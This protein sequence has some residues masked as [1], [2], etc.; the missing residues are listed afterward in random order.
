MRKTTGTKWVARVPQSSGPRGTLAVPRLQELLVDPS[1]AWVL[2]P[3][4]A[5]IPTRNALPALSAVSFRFL[6]TEASNHCAEQP[7][8][9]SL[10]LSPGA[11]IPSTGT[12]LLTKQRFISGALSCGCLFRR[13]PQKG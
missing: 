6:E 5:R 3:H 2:D 9:S 7:V 13:E 8:R 11:R 12:T 10:C 4:T 1:I